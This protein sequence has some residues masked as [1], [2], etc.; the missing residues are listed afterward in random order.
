MS[1]ERP[2]LKTLIGR[3]EDDAE[4]RIGVSQ[5]R[6]SNANVF[7]RVLAGAVHGLYGF[8]EYIKWVSS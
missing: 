5:L 8:I 7:S 2:T 3:I 4:S 1:F 6:R